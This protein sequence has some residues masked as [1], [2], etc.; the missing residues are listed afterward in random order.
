MKTSSA[1]YI[2]LQELW[3]DSIQLGSSR[4]DSARARW[5]RCG[6]ESERIIR[7]LEIAHVY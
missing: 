4:F 7:L 1:C 2:Q 5:P 6:G 3:I